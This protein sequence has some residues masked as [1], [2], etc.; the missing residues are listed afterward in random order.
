MAKV[1]KSMNIVT[2]VLAVGAL[3]MISELRVSLLI[4]YTHPF[5]DMNKANLKK[6]TSRRML[7]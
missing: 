1:L 2:E 6:G 3:K 7:I 4:R 5:S